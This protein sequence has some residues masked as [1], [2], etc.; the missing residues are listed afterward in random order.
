MAA[1]RDIMIA[2]FNCHGIKSSIHDIVR[3]CGE[4]D[5]LFL[6]ETWLRTC[7]LNFINQSSSDFEGLAWS[8]VDDSVLSV[9]RPFSGLAV[10][11][12]KT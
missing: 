6:Q 11:W 9:G 12:R 8:A 4:V 5:I 1:T 10:M 2:T 7:D 3:L